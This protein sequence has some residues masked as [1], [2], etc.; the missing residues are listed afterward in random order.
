MENLSH[1]KCVHEVTPTHLTLPG[2]YYPNV[3]EDK[4][5][6]DTPAETL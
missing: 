3:Y 6:L 4:Q 1:E 5:L 2:I